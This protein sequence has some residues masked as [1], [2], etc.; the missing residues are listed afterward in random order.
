MN[1][2]ILKLMRHND[3]SARL[4]A[5]KME[6]ALTIKLG[7]DWLGL[8]PEMLPFIA[9]LLEDDDDIVE[10]ETRRWIKKVEEILGESLDGM[11]R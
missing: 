10:M 1:S 5:V 3:A 9:E 7:E 4:A 6:Q 11:L 8:L 2:Q